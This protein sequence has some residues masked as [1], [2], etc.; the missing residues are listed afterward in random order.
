LYTLSRSP[1]SYDVSAF[2][3]KRCDH[4]ASGG[5]R[6]TASIFI[7]DLKEASLEQVAEHE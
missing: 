4:Q 3:P 2:A 1:G 5:V 7:A 6:I